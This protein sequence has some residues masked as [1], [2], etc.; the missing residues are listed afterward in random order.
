MS[1]PA[2]M[3]L[4]HRTP[5]YTR[6]DDAQKKPSRVKSAPARNGP[7]RP[8]SAWAGRREQLLSRIR[9]DRN[10]FKILTS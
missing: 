7:K 5:T 6:L 4:Y 10:D 1:Y 9:D 2:S 3:I 8:K